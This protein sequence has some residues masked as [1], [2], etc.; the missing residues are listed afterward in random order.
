MLIL[1]FFC[2]NFVIL[3]LVSALRGRPRSV[4]LVVAG[5]GSR[6]PGQFE[7]NR[8]APPVP[9]P[10]GLG[11]T[12]NQ[13]ATCLRVCLR[14]GKKTKT[15]KRNGF[16]HGVGDYVVYPTHGVGKVLGIEKREIIGQELQLFVISFHRDRMTLQVPVDKA[17]TSG[18]RK[19]SS[20]KIMDN[21]LST[22]KG[23]ARVKRTMWSR[24]A[25]EYEAKINS[26]DPHLHRRG[27][28]RPAPERRP[29]RSI[30]QRAPD[31]R[32]GS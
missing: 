5:R 27:R 1:L 4:K 14:V 25:Q 3:C 24:R 9:E 23:R 12:S 28:S 17:D 6:R 22:L 11:K 20:R 30:L 7:R 19:L 18:L 29:A 10:F 21:A 15:P 16:V 13:S 26:G 32:I 2:R 31:L 8:S